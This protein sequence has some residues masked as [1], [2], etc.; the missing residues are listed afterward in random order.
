MVSISSVLE[1]TSCKLSL[2]SSVIPSATYD[3]L[4]CFRDILN[5][6]IA[7]PATSLQS[8]L[9]VM[10]Y[11]PKFVTIKS[12]SVRTPCLVPSTWLTSPFLLVS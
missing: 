11:G 12:T 9:K 8:S 2:S 7:T 6:V 3:E 1:T 10:L 4:S 5:T